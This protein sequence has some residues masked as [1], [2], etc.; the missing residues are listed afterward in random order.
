M[1]LERLHVFMK[2]SSSIT[3]G[4]YRNDANRPSLQ[5]LMRTAGNGDFDQQR[6]EGS[7]HEIDLNLIK[8]Y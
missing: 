5:S 6:P 4:D 3:V 1:V 8:R 2:T 7:S